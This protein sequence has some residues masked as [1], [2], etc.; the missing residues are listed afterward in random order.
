MCGISAFKI[1]DLLSIKFSDIQG[2][3]LIIKESKTGKI[4]N[5]KLNPK[6]LERIQRIAR[7]HSKPTYQLQS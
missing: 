3:R 5:I 4:A 7:E 6:T 1:S 2:D